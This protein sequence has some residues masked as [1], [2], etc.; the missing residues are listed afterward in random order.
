VD[1][2]AWSWQVKKGMQGIDAILYEKKGKGEQ[3]TCLAAVPC[4]CLGGGQ[5][6]TCCPCSQVI[7]GCSSLHFRGLVK[8]T[9][10][11]SELDLSWWPPQLSQTVRLS[12]SMLLDGAQLSDNHFTW[13][14][15]LANVETTF[16]GFAGADYDLQVSNRTVCNIAVAKTTTVG[17]D[18]GAI[19]EEAPCYLAL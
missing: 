16:Q 9:N 18:L 15:R 5:S 10:P 8:T 12:S 13:L 4:V 11:S 3:H 2:T 19:P 14:C 6:S 17:S 7:Q 1:A